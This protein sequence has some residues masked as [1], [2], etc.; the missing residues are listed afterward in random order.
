[1]KTKYF[2]L[3][4]VVLLIGVAVFNW[5]SYKEEAENEKDGVAVSGDN[6]G[7]EEGKRAPDF[8]V[9]TIE[10]KEVKLS[11]YRGKKVF[12]NFWTTWC[13]PCK[14][15][16]PQMQYFYQNKP[17]NVEI[18]AVNIEEN[19]ERVHDFVKEY[20]LTFPILVDKDGEISK[21]YDVYTIPTTFVLNENGTIHQKVVGPMDEQM[22]NSLI[23][24]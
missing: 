3:F 20:R 1:M 13:P 16:M 18:L 9:Q 14:E 15:E 23:K 17:K 2:G 21:M 22:M 11:D 12:L 4:W 7:T 24:E 19:K 5:H 6:Y 10:G 8:T